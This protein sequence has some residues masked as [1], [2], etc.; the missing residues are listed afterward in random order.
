MSKALELMQLERSIEENKRLI[1][2]SKSLRRLEVNPD[3]KSIITQLY[4]K[5]EAVRLV[6]LKADPAMQHEVRQVA[7]VKDIDAIGSLASFLRT[8][9]VQAETAARSLPDDEETLIELMNGD[10]NG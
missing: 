6:H 3:Y 4:L 2:L 10:D 7:I 1:E 8:I 9:H 5:D